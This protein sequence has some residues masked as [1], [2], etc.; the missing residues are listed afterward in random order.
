MSYTLQQIRDAFS[1]F[2]KSK[3]HMIVPSYPIVPEQDPTLLFVNSGM[4]PLKNFFLGISQAPASTMVTC[5]KCLRVGGKHNDLEQIGYT[6]RHHTFFEMLGNFSFNKYFKEDAIKYAWEFITDILGLDKTRLYVTVHPTDEVAYNIWKQLLDEDRITKLEANF[7]FMGDEG[8]C[9]PCSEIFYDLGDHLEGCQPGKGEEGDRFLEIWNLVFMM[10]EQAKDGSMKELPG[11]CI[12]TGAGLER[13][14]AVLNGTDDTFSIPDMVMLTD[15]VVA[16]TGYPVEA[17]HKV[18]A[19]HA[20]SVAFLFA[21]GITP[22]AEGRSYILRKLIRRAARFGYKLGNPLLLE[23]LLPLVVESMKFTY[24]ELVKSNVFAMQSL[25][26][27]NAR[28]INILE[29]GM[30]KVEQELAVTKH[31]TGEFAFKLYDTYGF[32]LEILNDVAREQGATVDIDGFELCIEEQ[33]KRSKNAWQGTGDNRAEIDVSQFAPTKFEGYD[34]EHIKSQIIGLFVDGS[35]VESV[36]LSHGSSDQAISDQV[37]IILDSTPFYGESG[38]QKADFGSIKTV[39]FEGVVEDVKIMPNKVY[40]HKVSVKQGELKKGQIVDCVIDSVRRNKLRKYHTATHLLHAALRQILGEHIIQKGSL[41][42]P[43]RLRFDFAHGKAVSA[44]EINQVE[45][46]VNKWIDLNL[47]VSTKL[48]NAQDAMKEGAMALFGEKYP[49][50]VRVVKVGTSVQDLLDDSSVSLYANQIQKAVST[51][52]CGG[53]HV[54]SSGVIGAFKI[55]KESSVASGVRRVE[56]L[57]GHDLVNYLS[58]DLLLID[59]VCLKIKTDRVGL[60]AKLDKMMQVEKSGASDYKV[61]ILEG[62]C[63][64]GVINAD[65]EAKELT[66]V[67][68]Q[69]LKKNKDLNV[70]L[71]FAKEQNNCVSFVL[72]FDEK[73]QEIYGSANVYLRSLE[74]VKGGGKADL[75]Q[76]VIDVSRINWLKDNIIKC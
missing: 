7:W 52:L 37:E 11:K 51:E 67:V 25:K 33:K 16:Q 26:D 35:A 42:E 47:S 70:L 19:D 3:D 24:P 44:E 68:T 10:Y 55:I 61:D 15:Y 73:A 17:A 20:R 5:Q 43:N 56:C 62:K 18:L 50:H 76:G 59:Q 38:G 64:I 71:V 36:S 1:N 4:A 57:C 74:G 75:V 69:A 31:F 2:F 39:G 54:S 49:D 63:L 8:P 32:P 13:L 27:E 14:A 48:S 72:R 22:G 65:V 28:F 12:D 21:D 9:G 58:E 53:T 45:E 23:G 41:V 34:K 40:V 30:Q 66:E 46:L 29:Q 60:L 6:K